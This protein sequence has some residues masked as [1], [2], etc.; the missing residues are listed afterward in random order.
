MLYDEINMKGRFKMK[1]FKKCAAVLIAM[2]MFTVGNIGILPRDAVEDFM[3][4]VRAED[5][6]ETNEDYSDFNLNMYKANLMTNAEK[7]TV[8]YRCL[9]FYVEEAKTPNSIIFEL[10]DKDEAFTKSVT[11]W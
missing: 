1:I 9:S 7:D 6:Y 3:F 2:T 11:A 10:L 5:T 8:S 4:S